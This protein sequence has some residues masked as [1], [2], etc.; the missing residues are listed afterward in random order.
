MEESR[1]ELSALTH[2]RRHRQDPLQHNNVQINAHTHTIITT[3]DTAD[4]KM[5]NHVVRKLMFY[6]VKMQKLKPKPCQ[7]PAGS[8]KTFRLTLIR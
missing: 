4:Q 1:E 7:S 2:L 3:T 5:K 6:Q 8:E